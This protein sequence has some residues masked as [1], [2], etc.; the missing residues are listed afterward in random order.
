VFWVVVCFVI[1][2]VDVVVV[3]D[4]GVLLLLILMLMLIIAFNVVVVLTVDIGAFVAAFVTI[5]N[6]EDN[7]R[8]LKKSL[9]CCCR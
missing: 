9:L 7:F 6:N 1:V 2:Y 5:K 3:V 8:R 4:I